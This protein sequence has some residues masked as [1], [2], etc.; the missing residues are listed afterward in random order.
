MKLLLVAVSAVALACASAAPEAPVAVVP[1]QTQ[2]QPADLGLSAYEGTYAMQA[3]NRLITMRVWLDPE[4]RLNGELIG[5]GQQT[6]FR[7]SDTEHKFMHAT[8]DDVTFQFT[9]ENGRAT[10]VTMRQGEREISGP[11]TNP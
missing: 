11:R 9:V 6:T 7:A 1:A 4:G 2:T 3:P 8:R 5:M 10:S